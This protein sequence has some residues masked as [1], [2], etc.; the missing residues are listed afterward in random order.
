MS[1]GHAYL[2]DHKLVSVRHDKK[3]ASGV[4][5]RRCSLYLCYLSTGTDRHTKQESS[6]MKQQWPR[7]PFGAIRP[8]CRI[9]Q[10]EIW[11]LLSLGTH[12]RFRE[13]GE[14][15]EEKRATTNR[16]KTIYDS[17][18]WWSC[19]LA[20]LSDRRRAKVRFRQRPPLHHQNSPLVKMDKRA[21]TEQ[22]LGRPTLGLNTKRKPSSK[23]LRRTKLALCE[24]MR[25]KGGLMHTYTCS[26]ARIAE[27]QRFPCKSFWRSS[28]NC[29]LGHETYI[30]QASWMHGDVVPHNFSNLSR[31]CCCSDLCLTNYSEYRR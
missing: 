26:S 18:S 27:Q 3:S 2:L 19:M 22:R 29:A 6:R 7:F 10:Y 28:L 20:K 12:W 24:T 4:A 9:V 30:T 8:A 17:V 15:R 14:I 11:Q 5:C 25:M 21:R 1:I 31:W 16:P 13:V 23:T